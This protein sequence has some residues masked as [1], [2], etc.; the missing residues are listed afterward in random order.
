MNKMLIINAHPKMEASSSFSSKVLHHF[1]MNY[2]ELNPSQTMEQINLYS[3]EVPPVDQ[4]ALSA[5]D[6]LAKGEPI[7]AEEQK[8]TSRMAEVLQQFKSANKYVI[9]MPLHNFNIQLKLN[10]YID[11]IMIPRETFTYTENGSVGLLKDG[12]SL[13]V[14]Q[15]KEVECSHNY[16][17]SMFKFLG[18]E[19]YQ[20]I[21]GQ[22]T[23]VSNRDEILEN[24]YREAEE[25]ATYLSKVPVLM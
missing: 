1:L 12:R 11:N 2:K 23:A 24:A 9:A 5:W 22:T 13:L 3:D 19:D 16:L 25:A 15:D 4:T 8:V 6:K 21:K 14:I 7:T 10:D 20:I 18:V 17:K